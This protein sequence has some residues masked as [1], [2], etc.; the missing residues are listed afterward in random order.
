LTTFAFVVPPALI[1][2]AQTLAVR[3]MPG[4]LLVLEAAK[5]GGWRASGPLA[6][7]LLVYSTLITIQLLWS[8]KKINDASASTVN[9][10][11]ENSEVF[12][13]QNLGT[14]DSGDAAFEA[15]VQEGTNCDDRRCPV[16][17]GNGTITWEAKFL[18]VGDPCPLCLGSG[19]TKRRQG[20]LWRLLP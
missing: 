8:K 9:S 6:A 20:L 12:M 7:A 15:Y 13:D 5:R 17:D 3:A 19:V 4:R 10:V 1:K 18:H 2:V 11:E 14:A 16:C